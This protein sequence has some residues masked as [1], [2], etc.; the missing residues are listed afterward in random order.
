MTDQLTFVQFPH[1]GGEHR[2]TGLE[3][4][5]NTGLRARKFLKAHGRYLVEGEV[6]TGPFTF[7]GEWEAQSRIVETYKN[8]PGWPRALHEPYWDVPADTRSLQNTDPLVFGDRFLYSNCR[9]RSNGKLRALAPG[10]LILFGSKVG[11]QFALDTMFVIGHG[12]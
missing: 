6:R 8:R 12:S 1:P 10:S 7:W 9:Q 11:G 3:M 4:P 2:P 5:W